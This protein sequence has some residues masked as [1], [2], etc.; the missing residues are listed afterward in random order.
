M[1]TILINY[2]TIRYKECAKLVIFEILSKLKLL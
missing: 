2:T 1:S